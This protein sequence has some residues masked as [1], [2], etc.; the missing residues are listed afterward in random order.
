MKLFKREQPEASRRR[1]L[2]R[3]PTVESGDSYTFRR[4][5]TLTGSASSHVRTTGEFQADLKSSRVQ[6]HELRRKRRRIGSVL[7]GTLGVV[8]LLFALLS[9]FTATPVVQASPDPSLQLDAVYTE[10]IDKYLGNHTSERLRMFTNAENLTEYLQTVTPE[11]EEVTLRGSSGFGKSLFEITFRK[12]IASWNVNGKE[13]YV[14]AAGV[15]FTRNYFSSPTLRIT[16]QSGLSATLTG[17]SVMSNRFMSYVGQ[18]IGSSQ[19]QGYEVTTIV[20]PA[21]T[22][23]QIE[24]HIKDVGYPFKFSSDRPAREGVSDMVKTAQW[25]KSHQVNPEYVD[26][27]V[28]GK[29]FYK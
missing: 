18:V 24:V 11:V 12:P 20:I 21:G 7:V 13:L 14:D 26:V 6:I 28:E 15:P 16:D 19:E 25:M 3:T 10:A 17:Q 23:R 2:E 4:G 27:R 1:N 29:V 8:A 9:Q 22:T 5:R